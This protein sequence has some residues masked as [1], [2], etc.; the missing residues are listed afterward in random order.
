VLEEKLA[1][2][3]ETLDQFEAINQKLTLLEAQQK[4]L[5]GP[6]E[7]GRQRRGGPGPR[8]QGRRRWTRRRDRVNP[9]ARA[10][11]DAH[12]GRPEP[13]GEDERKA[14]DDIVNAEYKSLPSQPDTAGGYLAP[15]ELVH[16]IIK[17]E[18]LMSPFRPLVRVRQT[19]MRSI[20]IPKRTG[21]FAAVG[22]RAG[23]QERKPPASPTAWRRCRSRAL[24]ARRHLQPDAGGLRLRHA[25]RDQHGGVRAVRGRRRRR[26]RLRQRRRQAEGILTNA[27]RVGGHRL[28]LGGHHRGR[29][30]PGQRPADPSTR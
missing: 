3:N 15:R 20:H 5:E 24:C 28:R 14:I 4:A 27:R 30:R 8:R 26:V 17:A 22:R 29:Q 21:T 7:A 9:W 25:G 13:V 1:K 6:A 10:V 2:I 12:Q 16:E 18:V 19:A 23:D 11:V